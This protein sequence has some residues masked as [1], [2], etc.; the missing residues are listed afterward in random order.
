MNLLTIVL[1]VFL[2]I[3]LGYV[4]RRRRFIDETANAWL[5]RLVFFV[6]APALLFRSTAQQH[7]AWS[8]SA[9]ALAIIA[10]LT[11]VAAII[12]YG[13]ARRL[14]PARRGVLVQGAVRSNTVFVGLPLVLNAYGEQAL[15]PAS[16]LIAFMVVFENFLAVV[17]LT[18]PHRERSALDPR[19]WGRTALRIARNPLIIGCA[20]GLLYALTGLGLPQALERSL[21]LVGSLAA[22]LGLLCVG[23]GLDLQKLRAEIPGTAVAAA[24]KLLVYPGLIYGGL[25]LAGIEG[26]A[27]GVPVLVMACPTA[28]VSYIMAR[29]MAGDERLGAAIVIGTTSAAIVTLVAWLAI[30]P[31]S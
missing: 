15:G 29:E 18:L 31:R 14:P 21:A 8:S 13:A 25:R 11:V 7:F 27:L 5:S 4:L 12:V 30:L 6:A 16:V 28:V 10:G 9:P 24:I 3:G 19:L 26:L 1:P 2:V 20:G 22:P 23:A 17:V